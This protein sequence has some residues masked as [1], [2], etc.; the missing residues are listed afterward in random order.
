MPRPVFQW[1]GSLPR[2]FQRGGVERG[3]VERR[4]RAAWLWMVCG[5]FAI[6]YLLWHGRR[7]SRGI[8][9]RD[10]R[11]I[12]EFRCAVAPLVLFALLWLFADFVQ[13]P[14]AQDG[15]LTRARL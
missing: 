1:P 6:L 7:L 2:V 5:L 15:L 10:W 4:R 14:N 8:G 3:R 12:E 11:A 13:P 9:R